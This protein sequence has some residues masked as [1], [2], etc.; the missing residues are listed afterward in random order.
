V[1]K[2]ALV[3]AVALIAA[4]LARA[5]SAPARVIEIS[6]KRFEFAPKEIT[7]KAGE[8]VTIRLTAS[9]HAHGLL[10]KPLHID[11]DAMPGKPDEVT[12]TPTETGRYSAICDD[13]C[14]SGH[15]GMKM[16]FIVE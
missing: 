6:A 10:L 5:Q 8:P 3:I 16:T 2:V 13:Y 9:D 14:G 12:I 15:G 4:A 11:L 7:L 1:K